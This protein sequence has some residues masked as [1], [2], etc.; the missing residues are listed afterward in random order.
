MI[1]ELEK[2][3]TKLAGPLDRNV[4]PADRAAELV[5]RRLSPR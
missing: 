5:L 4:H 2:V 1:A 3:K